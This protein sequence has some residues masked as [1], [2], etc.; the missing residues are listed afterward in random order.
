MR[1][2][3]LGTLEVIS[4]RSPVYVSGRR[5]RSPRPPARA[6]APCLLPPNPPSFVG[7]KT[8]RRRP[9]AIA[10][11]ASAHSERDAHTAVVAISTACDKLP[12]ALWRTSCGTTC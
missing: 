4:S 12:L 6:P 3:M 5:P 9:A 10:H 8:T 11:A 1:F 7:R 2:Q